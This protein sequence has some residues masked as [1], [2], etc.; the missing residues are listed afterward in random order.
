ML[1][2]TILK[3]DGV[4]LKSGSQGVVIHPLHKMNSFDADYFTVYVRYAY[5]WGE[6]DI[7]T[8]L[9]AITEVWRGGIRIDN[10]PVYEQ[11]EMQL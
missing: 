3:G 5:E 1:T 7:P 4:V 9:R 8:D 6:A 2:T 10:Q 11:M